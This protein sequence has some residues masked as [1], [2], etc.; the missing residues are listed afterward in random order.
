MESIINTALYV[1]DLTL[2]LKDEQDIKQALKFSTL[3]G[4][5]IKYIGWNQRQNRT[6][7]FFRFVWK[8]RLKILGVHFTCD[9]CASQVEENWTGRAESIKRVIAWGTGGGGGGGGGDL[10]IAGKACIIIF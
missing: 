6:D 4:L 7:T 9:K 2:F 8:T 10:S 5:E 1:D 3:S